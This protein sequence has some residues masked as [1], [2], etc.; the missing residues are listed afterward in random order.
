[1]SRRPVK[2]RPPSAPPT[3]L[4]LTPL[5]YQPQ[6]A[7]LVDSPPSGDDWLHEQ[8]FDGYR[9]GI[10]VRG[11]Q[12]RLWS[13]RAQDWTA[14]M[15]GLVDAARQLGVSSAVLDGEAAALLPN[16]V[17]SF[18]ALQRAF[19]GGAASN[20]T[21]FAF[22]LLWLDG[23]DLRP[24]PLDERKARLHELLGR[25]KPTK[26]LRYS[27]HVIGHGAEFL[28]NACQMGLEGI[29]SKRRD[30]R[31][32]T[33]RNM[34]WQKAKCG[35]RQELV[36]GGFTDPEGARVGVGSLLVGYY[37]GD[38]LRWAGNVG[39]GSGWNEG[40]LRDL[41][42]KLTKLETAASPFRPPVADPWLRRHAHWV[43]PKLVGEVA[44]AEWTDDGRVRHGSMK[45]IRDDKPARAV[46]RETAVPAGSDRSIAAPGPA[47]APTAPRRRRAA[48]KAPG[49]D[50]ATTTVAEIAISHPERVVYP[51]LGATKLDIARYYDA[52]SAW[53]LPH[54]DAR[55]LTLLRCERAIDPAAPD[56]KGGCTMM[57]HGR[58][59]GPAALRRITIAE[60]RKTGEYLV[61]ETR[62]ALVA[63]AQMDVV[64]I[65]TW[66]GRAA[67][68]Y[69][70]DRIVIDLDPGPAVPWA[71]VVAAARLVRS[72]FEA[73][74]LKS[75]VKTTGG[76]GLHVVVP[77]APTPWAE[78][79]AFARAIATALVRH[80]GK[81]FTTA[82]AKAGREKRIL[83][84][85][86]RNNR[87]NTSAAAYSLRARPEATVSMPIA[88][89]A[90][91]PRL[92]PNRFTIRTVPKLLQRDDDP[93]QDAWRARQRLPRSSAVEKSS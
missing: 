92:N 38:E 29:V 10:V 49:G 14:R 61:A 55:P 36:I 75:W 23:E 64:E 2:A 41:R 19:E 79:L 70:H 20:I 42:R 86:L 37:E 84:D 21:Y 13:R 67:S 71:D 7:T 45:G 35:K 15:P 52:V 1:M 60:T 58:A 4:P 85:V 82:L 87:A 51:A 78:C 22:D 74:E 24:L 32:R 89:A 6:L 57:R 46:V 66:N 80:E 53:M 5:A 3:P 90:L 44:F 93:W 76:E 11:E 88:W 28:T 72:A 56:G 91:T 16:G 8:K 17:T 47:A 40:Y 73:V 62:A 48:A 83:L 69:Q 59:W 33:G 54:I 31:Y 77:I 81:R 25:N 68:P 34:D 18:Q 50:E 12:V 43:E 63:L 26:I 27:D 65:H 9:I 30:A 39:T